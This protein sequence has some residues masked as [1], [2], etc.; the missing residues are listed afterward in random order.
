MV[1]QVGS[2]AGSVGLDMR[3]SHM[4]GIAEGSSRKR[5]RRGLLCSLELQL[6]NRN[7]TVFILYRIFNVPSWRPF[8]HLSSLIFVFTF[9]GVHLS[10]TIKSL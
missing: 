7:I 10:K 1:G 6:E 4:L 3:Y 8:T 9:H 5:S 2:Y